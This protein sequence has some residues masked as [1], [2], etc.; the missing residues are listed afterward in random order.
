MQCRI[1][2]AMKVYLVLCNNVIPMTD[3][4]FQDSL[5]SQK[6]V[7]GSHSEA[8]SSLSL[9]GVPAVDIKVEKFSDVADS[10]DPV[11]MTAVGIKTEHEVSCMSPLCP[12]L[13]ILPV[14]FLICIF[15][16]KLLQSGE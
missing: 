3:N 1:V 12:L 10:R 16:T 8:C 9:N 13:G 2:M 11:P 15:H 14:L 7:P 5:D 6:D 4:G